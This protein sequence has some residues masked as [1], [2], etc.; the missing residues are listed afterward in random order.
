MRKFIQGIFAARCLLAAASTRRTRRHHR[1]PIPS[2]PSATATSVTISSET[3]T[4]QTPPTAPTV[5]T[6]RPPSGARSPAWIPNRGHARL[7]YRTLPPL[8]ST[9]S[10]ASRR[11]RLRRRKWQHPP[12]NRESR[13]R[14]AARLDHLLLQRPLRAN[15]AN[16]LQT[17]TTLAGLGRVC[18]R[19][20]QTASFPPRVSTSDFYGFA[21]LFYN[22]GGTDFPQSLPIRNR[23]P[24]RD[25][26]FPLPRRTRLT[27][28][29][30]RDY[31]PKVYTPPATL[32]NNPAAQALP[33]RS[34]T[35]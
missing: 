16:G 21:H 17:G 27:H 28:R 13:Q 31:H 9:P 35:A 18:A 11:Q 33:E 25:A 3:S 4:G 8:P 6:P 7:D 19:P 15:S 34:T 2:S 20:A 24:V 29:N 22:N 1:L 14:R 26:N 10:P 5:Y 12:P 23:V 30:H 32:G